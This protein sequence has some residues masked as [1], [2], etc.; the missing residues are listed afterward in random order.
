MVVSILLN[1]AN[2]ISTLMKGLVFI[3]NSQPIYINSGVNVKEITYIVPDSQLHIYGFHYH[4][5]EIVVSFI[6]A[7]GMQLE[8]KGKK[9]YFYVQKMSGNM[10]SDCKKPIWNPQPQV[11]TH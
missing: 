4:H 5:E 6:T 8:R 10:L 2:G 7:A 9:K 3:Q 11:M 1:V